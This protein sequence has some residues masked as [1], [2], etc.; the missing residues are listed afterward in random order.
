MFI[1]LTIQRKQIFFRR[2]AYKKNHVY[3]II[4]IHR[5]K[6]DLNKTKIL[7]FDHVL[8]NLFIHLFFFLQCN[9]LIKKIAVHLSCSD[10]QLF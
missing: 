3:G 10:L 5:K 8:Q 1:A 9:L 2:H 4:S 7:Q 6:I